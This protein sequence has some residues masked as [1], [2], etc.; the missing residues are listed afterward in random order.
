MANEQ[1]LIDRS[2]ALTWGGYPFNSLKAFADH[3]GVT[4]GGLAYYVK[5]GVPWRGYEIIYL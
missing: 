1:N 4:P 3:H 2:K 5:Y